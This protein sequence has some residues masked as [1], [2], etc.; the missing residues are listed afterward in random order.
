MENVAGFCDTNSWRK[1]H[2]VLTSLGYH[3]EEYLLCPS[4]LLGVPNIRLRYYCVAILRGDAAD[5]GC[6][7]EFG[8]VAAPTPTTVS[9][10]TADE[11][12]QSER[13]SRC[14]PPAQITATGVA[15][16]ASPKTLSNYLVPSDTMIEP[17]AMI[18]VAALYK[19]SPTFRFEIG[20]GDAALTSCFTKSYAKG[21][22]RTGA[23]LDMASDFREPEPEP[24]A[25]YVNGSHPA[26]AQVY[27]GRRFVCLSGKERLRRLLPCEV[28]R[29][30]HYPD[31]FSWPRDVTI[32]DQWRLLGNGLHIGVVRRVLEHLLV[33]MAQER[34]TVSIEA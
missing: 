11:G 10:P 17:E 3:V 20:R 26:S 9:M 30:L 2:T 7:S 23:L 27:S 13:V 21:F 18:D 14:L 19:K 32:Q 34:L 6:S 12:N 33:R 1:M 31:D 22:F 25:D 15:R 4:E 24:E 5:S 29:L 8:A 16:S 28:M